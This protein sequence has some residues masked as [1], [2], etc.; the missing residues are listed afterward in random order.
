[1]SN[2]LKRHRIALFLAPILLAS[3]VGNAAPLN[4]GR[5]PTLAEVAGWDIDVRP[6]GLGLPPGQGSVTDGEY[7]YDDKC[8]SCHGIFGEGA[9]RWPKLAGGNGTLAD[10]RPDKTVGSY[11][12]YASTLWDYIHRAMP[13]PAPQSL[14][15]EEVYAITAYVLFLNDIVDEDFVLSQQNLAEIVMPNAGNFYR[16][17]RPDVANPRCMAECKDPASIKIVAS[18]TG[19]TPTDHFKEDGNT[20]VAYEE[21][22]V[23]VVEPSALS[24]SAQAGQATY[25]QA[26]KVCHT[27]GLAG[28]PKL[29]DSSDWQIRVGTGMDTL[30]SHAIKGFQG[31]K[32]VMPAK[33]GQTQIADDLVRNAVDFM[34]ESSR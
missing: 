17:D 13:F 26:C 8:S 3:V 27:S 29:G 22:A 9:K 10:D 32:G 19:I 33:G 12:P 7:L 18:L 25:D 28:A 11:W 21:E 23:T 34:V 16:D 24:A 4:L 20:G 2:F 6:D 5:T 15:T 1:M 14:E 31:T 30:Y